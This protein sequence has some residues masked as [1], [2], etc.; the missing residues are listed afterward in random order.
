MA[1]E[2]TLNRIVRSRHVIAG[3][4][5][6]GR[7]VGPPEAVLKMIADEIAVLEQ[8]AADHPDR[9]ET[10]GKLAGRYRA[11]ADRVRQSAH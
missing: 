10:L 1:D 8:I 3:W 2:K 7:P 4:E 6:M 5:A 11:M 9:A